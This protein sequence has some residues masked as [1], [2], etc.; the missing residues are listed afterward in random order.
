MLIA[1]PLFAACTNNDE[2]IDTNDNAALKLCVKNCLTRS[3]I[4]GNSLSEDS[5]LGVF[6][7]DE[8][9]NVGSYNVQG[10]VKGDYCL[11]AS[12][13]SLSDEPSY[14]Y[15][16]YPYS[17]S[18][19]DPTAITYNASEQTDI[20]MGYSDD[21]T[22]KLTYVDNSN[23]TANMLL[24]HALTRVTLNIKKSSENSNAGELTSV[25]LSNIAT[26][27][28]INLLDHSSVGTSLGTISLATSTTLSDSEEA[29]FDLLVAPIDS[30]SASKLVLTVDGETI[31]SDIPTTKT[32][33][34]VAGRQYTYTVVVGE[35]SNVK[36]SDPDITLW[37]N[38][39]QDEIVISRALEITTNIASTRSVV[40]GSKFAEGDEV[41][42]FA[43]NA[44]GESYSTTSTNVKATL[45]NA[46]W[47]FSQKI[48]L[49]SE[50]A[51]VYGYYPYDSNA[52]IK[53][54][55]VKIDV[56]PDWKIGQKDYMYSGCA[57]ADSLNYKTNMTFNHAL[58]R[59]TLAV[60]KGASDNGEGKI[61][62]V[63]LSN[64]TANGTQGTEIAETG[65]LK[66]TDGSVARIENSDDKVS[67]ALSETATTSGTVNIEI[68]VIPNQSKGT[69]ARTASPVVCTLTIDGT[70]HE[71]TIS[72]P[73]WYPGEQYTYPITL[74]RQ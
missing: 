29:S 2:Q 1:L 36:I 72:N 67:L 24:T 31:Y 69:E 6:V 57:T 18:N 10:T 12:T 43:Y 51:L 62:A 22:G 63:E 59:I 64:G 37:H 7:A 45:N 41:G 52:T 47:Q 65:W 13:I 66:I 33:E 16:Y 44:E 30:L 32:E 70:A 27:G 35:N 20:L 28:S 50:Q 14:V 39:Q 25:A 21:G 17:S 42:I 4:T 11:L 71:F 46:H 68:L 26:N 23:P 19:T 34:W 53:G 48:A 9:N 49:T 60:K 5:Q 8:D 54:D 15:A 40:T 55:S 58:S 73:Q 38:N 61:T 56:N 3:I 74:S